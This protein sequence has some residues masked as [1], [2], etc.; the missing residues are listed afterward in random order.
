MSDHGTVDDIPGARPTRRSVLSSHVVGRDGELAAL[1]EAL[2]TAANGRGGV[3]F[4]LGEAGIGKSRLAQV[5]ASD[6]ERRGLALLR[7]RAVR[8]ITP[9]PYRP[10]AE[11]LCA[12]VRVGGGL[13]SELSPFRAILGRLVPEW[14]V[15][16][17]GG[18][19]DSVVALAEAVLRFLRVMAGDRGC[20]LVLEDLHWA[21][22]ETLAIVEYLADNLT[23]E[24]VLCLGTL[25]T[26]ERTPG[27]DLA[28]ALGARRVSTILELSR[29]DERE[30]ADMVRSC[31]N[32]AAVP[33]EVLGLTAR[34]DGVPF[35]VEE[36]LAVAVASGALVHDGGSWAMS[37]VVE[38]VV[39]LTFADSM[40]R[41]LEGL[42]AEPRNV[43][44][45][46]AVLGR[47]FDWVLLP[48][49]TALAE[50]VVLAGLHAAVDAQIV[51]V[52]VDGPAFRF[53]HA[54]SR[55]AVL[56]ELL[57][58]ERSALSRRALE[59]IEAAR[60]GLPGGWCELAAELA[61]GAGDRLRAATLLAEAGRRALR[62]GALTSAE[63]TLERAC[64]LVPGED[65]IVADVEGC[66]VE[67]L[68][69]AGKHDR[70]VEVGE[71][72]L[73]RL[74]NDPGAARKRAEAHLQ[75]ARAAVA[76]THWDEARYRLEQARV[77][78][79]EGAD[80]RLAARVNAL[81]AQIAILRHPEEAASLARTALETSE[82]LDLP[83]VACEALEV[84]GRFERPHDLKAA[85][86]AFARAYAIA[87]DHDLTV[88]R[89]RALHELGTIDLVSGRALTRLEEARQLALSQ[90]ALATVA[91]L[92]VQLAA[93]LAMRENP[94]AAMVAARR[95]AELARRH[96]LDQTLAAALAFEALAH[97]RA[98]RRDE[99]ERCAQEAMAHGGDAPDIAVITAF[100]RGVLAFVEEDRPESISQLDRAMASA[101]A[102]SGDQ[103]S[104]PVAGVWVLVREVDAG[105]GEAPA[106]VTTAEPVHFL[107]RAYIRYAEAVAS[108]RA[109]SS[110]QALAFVAEADGLLEGFEWFR[111]YGRR[112]VAEAAVADNWGHPVAWLGEA[113]AFFEQL[114]QERIASA[115][116]SLLRRA[117]APVRRRR[118]VQDVP[119]ALRA[120]GVTARE[121]E[122]LRLLATGMS[123]KEVGS[124]LYLSPR[125]VERHI[126]NLVA[127]T[128]VERRTQLVALAARTV[129]T[130][131]PPA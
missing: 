129:G 67:V 125:T 23:S 104:G 120:L 128:G 121:L 86:V 3:V 34:A 71:S 50:N 109:G 117:G 75:L 77:D 4:L 108:G 5:M 112:L 93:G 98:G 111:Q 65:P 1:D 96:R 115:C 51:A 82:R 122:V 63:V 19:D 46:A 35:L 101:S 100:G 88:W 70:A 79:A 84:L 95:G 45:A 99:V 30:V 124:R 14:R 55:D 91:V 114:G 24:R 102:S 130:G 28:G 56:G 119:P 37:A 8:T 81:G 62:R 92:E 76:A 60:P 78:A 12:A 118:G 57:P 69:L 22:P 59:A 126:A 73:R 58:P 2:A 42:G 87:N 38:P 83:E 41:R 9:V 123:N 68:S 43:L 16:G 47:R 27:R 15:E 29:L 72:L 127:K 116:R 48:A 54:L 90:G 85:E 44:L 64:A 110:E 40:R 33:D 49:L 113:Q 10:L 17:R 7:G 66:L 52:D 103:S 74:G 89:S 53:R 25:R 36:L 21:D 106:R 97:A 13:T 39:P 80:E 107:A 131:V 31:L 11:A 105:G 94:D 18:L 20:L 32:T 6:A 61:E 26:E